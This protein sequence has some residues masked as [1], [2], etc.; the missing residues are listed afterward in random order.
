MSF[1]I[2]REVTPSLVYTELGGL[3]KNLE[4][5]SL[6]VTYEVTDIISI[7]GNHAWLQYTIKVEGIGGSSTG[8]MEMEYTSFST[9]FED[10]ENKLKA[11]FEVQPSK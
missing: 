8:V 11:S 10:A 1:T 6:S 4:N 5:V 2:Q 9:L 3:F 7:A